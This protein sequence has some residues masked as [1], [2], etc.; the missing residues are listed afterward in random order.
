MAFLCFAKQ[1]KVSIQALRGFLVISGGALK[2]S[3]CL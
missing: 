3:Y 1:L 2:M